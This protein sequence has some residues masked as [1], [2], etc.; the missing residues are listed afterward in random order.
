LPELA[1]THPGA[2]YVDLVAQA[3]RLLAE[4]YPQTSGQGLVFERDIGG[5]PDGGNVLDVLY[6]VMEKAGIPRG[7]RARRKADVPFVQD[8]FARVT[9][10][11]AALGLAA[12]R[13]DQPLGAA[14]HA[15]P[16]PTRSL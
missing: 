12:R 7:E 6:A 14:G 1:T 16:S 10:E 3:K 4:W 13:G 9:L 8:T 15:N 5:H 11:S 2:A